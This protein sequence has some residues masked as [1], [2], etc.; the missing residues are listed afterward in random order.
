[1]KNLDPKR[2]AYAIFVV[3]AA[4]FCGVAFFSGGANITDLWSAL[5]I[6]Y[7]AIPIVLLVAGL[8]V[9]HMW[10][11]RVF[12]GWLVPF[13]DL[14]GTWHGHIRS[15]WVDPDTGNVSPPIPVILSVKQSFSR[16]SCVMRTAEMTSRSYLA[17][18]WLDG[19]E[20]VRKLGYSYHSSPAVSIRDRSQAHDGSVV[21]E[22]VGHPVNKLVGTYW[23]GRKTTGEIELTFRTVD[24]LDEFPRD[25]ASIPAHAND[26]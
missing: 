16:I 19:D 24:L 6:G 10:R 5:R 14:N 26:G 13:P 15:T 18:F 12:R 9:T 25:A 23:T 20:Q 8:F 21:Y 22:L 3:F 2:F 7:K 11:W 1:M 4:S 17:G